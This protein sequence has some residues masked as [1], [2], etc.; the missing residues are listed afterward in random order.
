MTSAEVWHLKILG[1]AAVVAPDGTRTVLKG[2]QAALVLAMLWQ[3]RRAV[4]RDELAELIWG[5]DGELSPH[6]PGAVRG[7]LSKLRAQLSAAGLPAD[8]LVTEGG[9]VRIALPEGATLDASEAIA[10]VRRSSD[11]LR[12][13][14]FEESLRLSA[15]AAEA[16][17]V[18]V[19]LSGD[20][21]WLRRLHLSI[22]SHAGEARRL[23]VDALLVL[24]RA[25]EAVVS[26]EQ[27]VSMDPLDEAAHRQL[28]TALV[29]TGRPAAARRAH[30]AF[31]AVLDRELGIS[32][33]ASLA[34]ALD[35]WTAPLQSHR[36]ARPADDEIFLRRDTELAQ[37][38]TVAEEVASSLTPRLAV[39]E[40]VAG[41]GKTHLA[42]TFVEHTEARVLWG[43]CHRDLRVPFEPFANA[44]R[45]G[46]ATGV[47]PERAQP[48]ELVA[49]MQRLVPELCHESSPSKLTGMGDDRAAVVHDVVTALQWCVSSGP[50][51]LVVDD[52]HWA[53]GDSIELLARVLRAVQGPLLVIATQR[54]EAREPEGLAD[55]LRASPTLIVRLG[56][57]GQA[58][59]LPLA[60][61]LAASIETPWSPEALAK[62]LHQRTGGLPYYVVE[63][64]LDTRRRAKVE[65]AAVPETARAWVGRRLDALADEPRSVLELAAVVGL[66]PAVEVI[67]ACWEGP[68]RRAIG[69][70]EHLVRSGFLVEAADPAHV[71]F[72]HEITRDAVESFI[73]GT[74]RARLHAR[75]AE[76]LL[77]K[78]ERTL[79]DDEH[80]VIPHA[81][82]ARHF[83][84]AGPTYARVAL[85]HAFAAGVEA[86]THGAWSLARDHLRAALDIAGADVAR[87]AAVLVLL[88]TTSHALGSF[89]L[90]VAE[91][92]EAVELATALEDPYL[93]AR[94][95]LQL[96]GRGGRG[97]A[98]D[99]P[100]VE[101]TAK[102]RA[103]LSG[104]ESWPD[105]AE[106]LEAPGLSCGAADRAALRVALEGEIAWALLFIGSFEER[107][108]LLRTSLLRVR[109]GP[110]SVEE[111]SHALIVQ[112]NILQGAGDVARRLNVMEEALGLDPTGVPAEV[113]IEA[114]LGRHE[115]LLALGDRP[116]AEASLSAARRLAE[117]HGFPYWL[118]AI[119]TWESL[120]KL[121]DGDPRG[122]EAA[123]A[124]STSL[125]A[126]GSREAAACTAVQT[127]CI[128]LY[129][130]RA[131]EVVVPLMG[132]V[133]ANPLIPCYRAVLALCQLAAGDLH[134]AAESYRWFARDDFGAVAVDSNRLLTLAVLG[135]VAVALED[136]RGA[137][138][139]EAA[140][141]PD[142][143]IN[144]VLNC[145][146]G[147]GA[148][149][150]PVARV[151]SR[152]LTLLGR[153]EEA[154][155]ARSVAKDAV[156]RLRGAQRED[157]L[158]ALR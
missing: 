62:V 136:Q 103:A 126:A 19:A 132:A 46:V 146:G 9:V 121:I 98:L 75:V 55:L 112:R 2:G 26:A 13:G 150:G 107:D 123:L 142:D 27:A 24:N 36:S 29:A 40:G 97:A 44:L 145:Y 60:T 79:G 8:T 87:R 127:V 73:G 152:L 31:V 151:R 1:E 59:L 16:L 45:D 65:P 122:A 17:A 30:D 93:L 155:Q 5:E 95:T 41:V 100:D 104:I 135:D 137:A 139:L 78:A 37:L 28:I 110:H 35:T 14:S 22:E 49:A 85:D 11:A 105:P 50:L 18:P 117:A 38:R 92:S 88:G 23:R 51:I 148:Y 81:D 47:I 48:P 71:E 42:R 109:S 154:Q 82:L 4:T 149:W 76:F 108:Q 84:L 131:G 111:L 70:L 32:P 3:E 124:A 57:V 129:Q 68:S 89:E 128:R 86:L 72:A 64:A 147:G 54:S 67:E 56:H 33:G 138:W 102:L 116:A 113:A 7:V 52:L 119:A 69:C 39:V 77:A 6:W 157:R 99:M 115:D 53:S 158:V 141:E 134:G 94:A 106:P 34:A 130:G 21:D 66:K 20:G 143:A 63:V 120:G 58:D 80:R 25:E 96:V 156:Q 125:R 140:L 153:L 15:S 12:A 118:W 43:R 90:A 10:A 114:H 74:R 101:R 133:E 83:A 91:L 144:V 61:S